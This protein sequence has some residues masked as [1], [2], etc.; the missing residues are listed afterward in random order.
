MFKILKRNSVNLAL[1]GE[2][3]AKMDRAGIVWGAI[4]AVLFTGLYNILKSFSPML[5][6]NNPD[7]VHEAFAVA[8]SII[9][10]ILPTIGLLRRVDHTH[11]AFG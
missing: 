4:I 10:I 2:K 6:P 8:I 11:G 9:V 1:G 3:L 7:F 5:F